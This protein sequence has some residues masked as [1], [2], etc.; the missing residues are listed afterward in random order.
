M[1]IF[2]IEK[3][4][5]LSE[6]IVDLEKGVLKED[7]LSIQHPGQ[8]KIEEEGHYEVEQEYPNG[9]RDLKWVID[10]PGQDYIAPWTET[11]VIHIYKPFSDEELIEKKRREVISLFKEYLSNSDYKIFKYIEGEITKD[12]FKFISRNRKFW[13]KNINLAEETTDYN[14]LLEIE[15]K[16][17]SD[18]EQYPDELPDGIDY[19]IVKDKVKITRIDEEE[20]NEGQS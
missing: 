12:E 10:K 6:D 16:V 13:R 1:R 5:E 14:T 9:G 11:E 20:Q 2:D 7:T 4:I 17:Y 18:E 19:L 8:E 3:Q 15:K